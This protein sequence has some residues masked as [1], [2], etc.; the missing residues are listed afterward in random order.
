[1]LEWS[2]ELNI[3]IGRQESDVFGGSKPSCWSDMAII[4]SDSLTIRFCLAFLVDIKEWM[5]K[6]APLN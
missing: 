4:V 1:M 3:I 5:A 2:Q 6:I